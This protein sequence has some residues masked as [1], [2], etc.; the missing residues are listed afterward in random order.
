M[1]YKIILEYDGTHFE[2][3]QSQSSGKGVQDHVEKALAAFNPEMPGT[4]VAGRT[5][6]GVHALGQ[7][8][9]VDIAREITPEKLCD[10]LNAHL[11]HR[12]IVALHAEIVGPEFSARRDAKMRHYRYVVF[13]RKPPTAL[14]AKRVWHMRHPLNISAMQTAA[15]DF[16]GQHDFTSFR[17]AACQSTRPVRSVDA[18]T[19][20]PRGEEIWFEISARAFLH[21]QVRNMVGTLVEIGRGQRAVDEIPRIIAAKDRSAAGLTAPPWGLYFVKVDY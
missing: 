1:R 12:P 7:V 14:L 2:G 11:R 17:S 13:C 21:H 6:T 10:A 15:M 20:T 18:F 5:D 3:W 16:L 8:I 19:I 9:S 4:T